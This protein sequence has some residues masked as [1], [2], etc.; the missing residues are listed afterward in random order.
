MHTSSETNHQGQSRRGLALENANAANPICRVLHPLQ[1][2]LHHVLWS[3]HIEVAARSIYTTLQGE[4]VPNLSEF[5][6]VSSA[7]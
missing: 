3:Q 6:Q 5:L 1:F 7:L 4:E 2:V